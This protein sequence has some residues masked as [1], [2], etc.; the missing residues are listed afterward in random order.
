MMN[1]KYL[2][3][4][5]D[6]YR[7]SLLFFL[8]IY[9]AA[10]LI[11]V[12]LDDGSSGRENIA[13]ALELAGGMSMAIAFFMPLPLFSYLHRRRSVDMY[14]AI[15]YS[16]TAQLLTNLAFA[17]IYAFG[18]F[19]LAWLVL[20][21]PARHAGIGAGLLVSYLIMMA[22]ICLTLML[23]NSALFTIGNNIVD[24]VIILAAYTALPLTLLLLLSA[25]QDNMVPALLDYNSDLA[26]W[27]SPLAMSGQITS[28][29]ADMSLTKGAVTM[30]DARTIIV[31]LCFCVVSCLILRSQVLRRSMERAEQVSNSRLAY[32][33]IIPLY[34]LIVLI[35]FFMS[36]KSGDSVG[37]LLLEVVVVFVAY[38]V[39]QFI[40]RRTL[41][42]NRRMLIG[43][44][45]CV[46]ASALF[47]FAAWQ[48]HGFGEGDKFVRLPPG[49]VEYS[50]SYKADPSD[51]SMPGDMDKDLAD[52]TFQ[53]NVPADG[54]DG[55]AARLMEDLRRRESEEFYDSFFRPENYYD[56]T[57]N[58]SL[59]GVDEG[60][61]SYSINGRGLTEDQLRTIA[62]HTGVKV[63]FMK[64]NGGVHK[65]YTLDQYLRR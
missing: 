60:Y 39:G 19:L 34:A 54:R 9:A 8:V 6:Q 33:L 52:V 43:F 10:V 21:G 4:L 50:Y 14:G 59:P 35:S 53:V 27:F 24:G 46:A 49:K 5:F 32:P 56:S 45:V 42:P 11:Q 30:F 18:T 57:L 22:L 58:V 26:K 29:L 38:A 2:R 13:A 55:E 64:A 47:T 51:L 7:V 1:K 15:P 44:A 17:Y 63:E 20:L 3:F 25:F 28:S 37:L 65:T 61:L 41:R 62:K 40:Y 31:L 36:A 12:L 23:F 16:R 48:T